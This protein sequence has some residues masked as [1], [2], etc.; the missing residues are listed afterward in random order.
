MLK[1]FLNLFLPNKNAISFQQ[2]FDLTELPIV[3]FNQGKNKYNFILDTGANNNII[4]ARILDKIKHEKYNVKTTLMG[5]EGNNSIVDVCTITLSYKDS[6]FSYGYLIKDM[7]GPFDLLKKEYGVNIHGI[8]GSKFF[9]EFQYVLDFAE[10][11]AYSK[12]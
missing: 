10:L 2:G 3:T 4:D 8:L 6:N 12:K 5:M 9:H 1:K 11:I 7:S